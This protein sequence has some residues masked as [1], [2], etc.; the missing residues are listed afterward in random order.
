MT[1]QHNPVC[2]N[3][4]SI[5][6]TLHTGPPVSEPAAE[7]TYTRAEVV[8]ALNQAADMASD[9]LNPEEIESSETIANDDVINMVVN[10]VGGLLDHPEMDTDQIIALQYKD[11]D[12]CF[13]DDELIPVFTAFGSVVEREPERGSAAWNAALVR[14]VKGWVT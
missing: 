11:T 5:A 8:S 1:E 13:Q 14:T 6:G 12:P 4:L 10:L 2:V 3:T 7:R 9:L